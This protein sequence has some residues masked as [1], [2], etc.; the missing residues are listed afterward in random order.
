MKALVT[1][2]AGFIGSHVVDRLVDMGYDV[3]VIDNLSSGKK[4]Y[5]ND[6][7]EFIHADL[8]REVPE[9]K[10]DE[11]W[12]IAANPDVRIG[13]E[14]PAEIYDNNILATF[15]LL[16]M[17]RKVGNDRIIFTSTSTVYGEAEVIPTPEDYPTVPI[18]IY[19]ASKLACEAL[20]T[21]YCHTFGMKSWIYRF[22]NVI[23]RRS[24]HGVIYDFIMK[25]KKNRNELEILGNGEQNK[26]YIYI[27]DC[28][29]AMF[30]GL[31]SDEAVNIFNIGSDDQIMVKKIAEIVSEEMGLSPRFVFTGGRRG[32]KGDVPI[33]LLSNEKLKKLGWMPKYSSEEAVRKAVRDLLDDLS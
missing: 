19:G 9:I 10:V 16:E 3:V 23:G 7:A 12:H 32:W 28:I 24:N 33:M 4:E 18:S 8:S 15:N 30:W 31:K 25:L 26:S 27:D 13:S 1:G 21:S 5:L 22:A 6:S 14:S 11:V 2:G 17:M 20:I 29:S